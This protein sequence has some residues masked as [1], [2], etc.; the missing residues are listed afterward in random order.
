MKSEP[1]KAKKHRQTTAVKAKPVCGTLTYLAQCR[2]T[3]QKTASERK[4]APSVIV[5]RIVRKQPAAF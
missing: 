4:E 5:D 3:P 1:V 2:G